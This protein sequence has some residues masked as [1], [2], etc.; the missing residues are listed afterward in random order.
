MARRAAARRPKRVLRNYP[1]TAQLAFLPGPTEL[2]VILIIALL[3]FGGSKLPSL[4]RSMGSSVTEFKKGLKGEADPGSS[5]P[6]V[7]SGSDDGA[8]AKGDG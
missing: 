1:M 2:W 8:P 5:K 6:K 7:G 3:L 4:A